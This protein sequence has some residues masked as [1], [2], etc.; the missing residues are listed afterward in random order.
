MSKKRRENEQ[1]TPKEKEIEELVFKFA[2]VLRDFLKD[3]NKVNIETAVPFMSSFALYCISAAM[4]FLPMKE[5]VNFVSTST[6]KSIQSAT[7]SRLLEL[8]KKKEGE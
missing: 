2:D 4:S 5:M 6:I 8:M 7:E 1:N 3:N